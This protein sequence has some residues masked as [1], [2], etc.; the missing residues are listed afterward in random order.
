MAQNYPSLVGAS[1]CEKSSAGAKYQIKI[2]SRH[3]A[4]RL[5]FCPKHPWVSFSRY[6]RL[7]LAA[8][9]KP[10]FHPRFA[11]KLLN[12]AL[13]DTPA[14]LIHGPRQCGKTILARS[15]GW[16]TPP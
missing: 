11:R 1:H 12:E 5:A 15:V 2:E 14:V 7:Q 10:I 4:S 16:G 9:N 6:I 13:A 8:M 3:L